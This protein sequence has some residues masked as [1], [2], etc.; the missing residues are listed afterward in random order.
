MGDPLRSGK[1]GER[2]DFVASVAGRVDA[3][4]SA[5]DPGLTRAAVQKL[6]TDGRVQLND[7]IVRKSARVEPGDS[8]GYELASVDHEP[9]EVRF[10]L[11][12][13]YE[14]AFAVVVD[15]PAGI[16]VHPAP[17]DD[18]ATVDDWFMQHYAP[19]ASAF[20]VDHPG[21]VHRLDRDTSG[22]LLLARTPSAQA[23][24]SAAFEQ[25]TAHKTYIALTAA[26]PRKD[27][28][29]IDAAIGRHPADRTRMAVTRNGRESRSTYEVLAADGDRCLVQVK[30]ETGRTHQIRV[31]LAAVGAPIMGDSVYGRGGEGRQLLHAWRLEI[32]HPDGGVIE[33]TA[34]LP[35]DM[36]AVVRSMGLETVASP[37]L[38]VHPARLIQD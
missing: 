18:A 1:P 30:P 9:R 10:D 38:D 25:R 27:R 19:D 2:R 3:V 17:G 11:P 35:E 12:V 31:H 7:A 24:F 29:V 37:Y 34:P 21:I 14:D 20:S 16:A 23:A 32:P 8:I 33:A 22:V 15:K 6:I 4:I 28:A 36:A 13:L 26:R 5:H